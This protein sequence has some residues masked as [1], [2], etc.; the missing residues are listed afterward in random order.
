MLNPAMKAEQPFTE[1]TDAALA[2]S[3]SFCWPGSGSTHGRTFSHCWNRKL[4]IFHKPG[5]ST[6]RIRIPIL[7]ESWF[8]QS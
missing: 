6:A 3:S 8:L 5:L 2:I 7:G 1:G 4:K